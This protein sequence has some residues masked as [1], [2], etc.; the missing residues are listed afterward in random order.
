[1]RGGG[2]GELIDVEGLAGVSHSPAPRGGVRGRG[3]GPGAP[4]FGSCAC[5]RDGQAPGSLLTVAL[6]GVL[7][8]KKKLL[9]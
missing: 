8:K 9:Y 5:A 3:R 6:A 4:R 7:E 2:G 1:M